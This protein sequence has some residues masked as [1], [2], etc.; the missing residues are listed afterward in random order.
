ME[1]LLMNDYSVFSKRV[2]VVSGKPVPLNRPRMSGI[3]VVYDSQKALKAKIGL[4]LKLQYPNVGMLCGMLHLHVDFYM[5]LPLTK[6]H[7]L[8][9]QQQQYHVY[10]PDISNL[11]KF[12]EDVCVDTRIIEDD[13]LIASISARKLYD[14]NPRTE[15]YFESLVK[16]TPYME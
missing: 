11:I 12:I 14:V 8:H 10:K 2:Y 1:V 4:E 3:G 5:P 13:C 16:E 9:L 7:R 15:F 6:Q